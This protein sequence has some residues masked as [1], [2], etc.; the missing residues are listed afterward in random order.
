MACRRV[1]NILSTDLFL[2]ILPPICI[3]RLQRRRKLV[4]NVANYGFDDGFAHQTDFLFN[5]R[6]L[7]HG[8][9]GLEC[10]L[11]D[12]VCDI[13]REKKVLWMQ[14]SSDVLLTKLFN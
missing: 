3:A 1:M 13:N 10:K 12:A 9:S 7:V 5:R 11:N 2:S 14:N 6:F 8:S 4:M